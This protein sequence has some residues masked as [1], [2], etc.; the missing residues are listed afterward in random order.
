M[1][2]S[3]N[4]IKERF[5]W[6]F[7]IVF[8]PTDPRVLYVGS[9]HL[10]KTTTEGQSWE[11]ISP[12]LTR[13]DPAT[14]GPSGGPITLD[15]TGVETY[16]TIFTIAPSPKD[17][18]VIWTGSDDGVVSV[19][20]DGGRT[21]NRV[22]PPDLPEFARVSL[23]EASPHEAG[24][25]FVAANRYQ[26]D[27]R[28]PYFYRT[29]D[30]GKTWKKIVGGIAPGD[31]ARAIREDP[32]RMGLLYAGTEHGFYV[33]FDAGS[34]WQSLRLN[35]P[36]TPVHDIAV[37]ESD[38]VIAT[39]G[40]SF[41]VLD[42]VAVLRQLT[43]DV[44]RS[45]GSPVRAAGRGP[46][47]QPRRD[48]RL[49]PEGR[50]VEGHPRHP[51]RRRPADSVVRGRG[52]GE[53]GQDRSRATGGGRRAARTGAEGL[54]EGRDEP[55]RLGHAT[56]GTR[57]DSEDDHVGGGNPGTEGGAGALPGASH[58]G[59]GAAVNSRGGLRDPSAPAAAERD[60]CRLPGA[61]PARRAGARPRH[62]SRRG[63]HPD[64]RAEGRPE[65]ARRRSQGR[66]GGAGRGRPVGEAHRRSRARSTSI[67][68]RAARTR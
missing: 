68:T 14:L 46:F 28:A 4:A 6:T 64:S 34:N 48:R 45:A 39:H 27:D 11:R 23:V 13:A 54:G 15:Q 26:R 20:R 65:G 33:S 61:V 43:P 22:T 31:F 2:H 58:R 29:Q 18:N 9:Q 17:A 41:Y 21:W 40:R 12:D 51:R 42:D 36:V 56:P 53:A 16:A 30:Y 19:T 8:A 7:P 60:G 52:R 49:L 44:V 55:V 47:G 10:W 66:R 3:S 38:V 5:Q 57:G 67:E 35:L 24:S 25:A 32:K 62:R 59:R 37:T 50:S 1:G 63:G